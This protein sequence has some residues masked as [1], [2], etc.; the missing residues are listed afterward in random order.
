MGKSK[1]KQERLKREREGAN[2]PEIAR[3]TWQRKPQTQVV[4]N[5]K[6]EQRRTYCRRGGSS[7]GAIF[8]PAGA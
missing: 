3:L 6:A 7:E 4:M 1:S 8:M 2:N 5:K